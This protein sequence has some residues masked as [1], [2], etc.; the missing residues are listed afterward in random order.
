VAAEGS[1]AERLVAG[2]P[3]GCGM[4][5]LLTEAVTYAVTRLQVHP[6]HIT[7]ISQGDP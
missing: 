6:I 7:D 1:S 3:A 4:W 2:R 5:I